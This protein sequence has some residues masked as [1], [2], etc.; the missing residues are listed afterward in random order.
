MKNT[1]AQHDAQ[2]NITL[3]FAIYHPYYGRHAYSG[4]IIPNFGADDVMGTLKK[5]KRRLSSIY[6]Y[7][8]KDYAQLVSENIF[9][10]KPAR[11][12]NDI[13]IL[14]VEDILKMGN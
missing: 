10:Y 4:E 7:T 1:K 2:P 12:G 13:E 6:G 8:D 14:G 5:L 3:A 9:Q 11:F